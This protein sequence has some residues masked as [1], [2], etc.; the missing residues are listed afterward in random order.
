MKQIS[1]FFAV[2]LISLAIIIVILESG[3]IS[4]AYAQPVAAQS[5]PATTH[6][7]ITLDA[8]LTDNF[9]QAYCRAVFIE[10][11]GDISMTDSAGTTIVYTVPAGTLL[12]FRPATVN[13]SGTD[14]T[15]IHCWR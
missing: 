2:N 8:D 4:E 1:T 9:G 10:G 13:T 14:A 12:P 6:S 11:A 3:P 7:T 5:A 15:G